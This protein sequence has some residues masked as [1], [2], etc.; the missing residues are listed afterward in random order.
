MA[1]CANV[2]CLW[3]RPAP[4]GRCLSQ[5]R[6]S[7]LWKSKLWRETHELLLW[8]AWFSDDHKQISKF[9]ADSVLRNTKKREKVFWL[10]RCLLEKS[11]GEMLW[12]MKKEMEKQMIHLF[13]TFQR[14]KGS[15]LLTSVMRLSQSCGAAGRG[16]SLSLSNHFHLHPAS[17]ENSNQIKRAEAQ[18]GSQISRLSWI[19]AAQPSRAPVRGEEMISRHFHNPDHHE[20]FG[21][22]WSELGWWDQRLSEQCF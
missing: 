19:S 6:G 4:S 22:C 11:E 17:G 14:G 3:R 15:A 20:L 2:S 9:R 21:W 16:Y 12:M 10:T 8:S 1:A 13:L 7:Q 18:I 5:L